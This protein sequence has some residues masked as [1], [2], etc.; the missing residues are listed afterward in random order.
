MAAK[1][2][3]TNKKDIRKSPPARNT[4]NR[5]NQ[6]IAKAYE[7]VEQRLNDGT[8]SAQEIVH[9]LKL[10]TAKANLEKEKLEAETKLLSVKQELV[11]SEKRSEEK[12]Q[13]AIDAFRRY[14]GQVNTDAFL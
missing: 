7:V 9:F 5:E 4:E 3:K 10:G 11:A 14:S 8:A 2:T 12:Y 13:E 1:V 6:L